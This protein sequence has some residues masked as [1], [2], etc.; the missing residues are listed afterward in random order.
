MQ[1]KNKQ[2][3][4]TLIEL[5]VVISIIAVLMSIM[6][7]AL[8]KARS[9]A[10]ATLCGS[11]QHQITVGVIAY[12]ADNQDLPP[13]IQGSLTGGIIPVWKSMPNSLSYRSSNDAS[14][15][16]G[17]NGGSVGRQL[18][19][20]LP[21]VDVWFCPLG[22]YKENFK[23]QSNN[24]TIE[25]RYRY[26]S[27]GPNNSWGGTDGWLSSTN[28]L[29]WNYQGWDTSAQIIGGQQKRFAGPGKNSKN[30]LILAEMTFWG[31]QFSGGTPTNWWLSNHPFRGASRGGGSSGSDSFWILP[32]ED[33][34]RAEAKF[35]K[36]SQQLNA[37][38]ID[39]SVRKVSGENMERITINKQNEAV[40]IPSAWR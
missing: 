8:T 40:Y 30:G 33:G 13:S 10:K 2:D 39:G 12:M 20:Y 1:Q 25:L 35:P 4:F 21:V 6:M 36:M 14:L 24:R 28:F 32:S 11:N 19:S 29:L 3:A 26:G 18:Y 31:Y 23:N 16:N 7:P 22:N 15:S 34:S 5:L 38:Y 17:L 27:G 37:G 9:Q